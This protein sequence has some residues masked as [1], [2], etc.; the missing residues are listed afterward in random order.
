MASKRK[1]RDAWAEEAAKPIAALSDNLPSPPPGT[2]GWGVGELLSVTLSAAVPL[3]IERLR[4]KPWKYIME[5]AAFCGQ[6]VAEKG[7]IIQFKSKKK[8]ETENAFNHLAEG[9]ACLAFAPG[10][11]RAFGLHFEAKLEG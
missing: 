8:G 4:R 11:V 5:R 10:G 3:W 1:S 7:D 9:L 2:P 6:V